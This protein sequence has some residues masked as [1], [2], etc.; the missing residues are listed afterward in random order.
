[1]DRTVEFKLWSSVLMFINAYLLLMAKKTV[2]KQQ[3][4]LFSERQMIIKELTWKLVVAEMRLKPHE[5]S[6]PQNQQG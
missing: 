5:S 2:P 1:M 4:L 6:F 3:P